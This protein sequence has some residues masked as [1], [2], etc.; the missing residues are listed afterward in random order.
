MEIKLIA[1]DL[2]GTLLTSDKTISPEAVEVIAEVRRRA[3]VKIVL[4]TAP[5]APLHAAV[6]QAARPQRPDDQL[7]RRPRLGA[8]DGQNPPAQAHPPQHRPRGIIKWARQRYPQIRV[9]AEIADKWYT[10]YYDGTYQ[11]ATAATHQPDLVAPISTWL[12]KP[13]TKLLL[14]GHPEWVKM[15]DWAI[16]TDIP[17]AVRTV[18]TED[19]MLQV[20]SVGAS[21]RRAVETLSRQMDIP[22][23]I[24]DGYRRQRQRRRH[25]PVG[26]R[27]RRDGQRPRRLPPGLRPRRRPPRQGRR[28]QH[29]AGPRSERQG[30]RREIGESSIFNLQMDRS[31]TS[32]DLCYLSI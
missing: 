1:I 18:Q 27:R 7:Q 3:D 22:P 13:V 30:T 20:M 12:T 29:P 10:D 19:Y 26:R 9:S 2:D 6:L 24:R 8:A 25:D 15:V 31:H 14:L 28:C 11:T 32:R 17:N 16:Q 23:G 21:K 4:A 5:P